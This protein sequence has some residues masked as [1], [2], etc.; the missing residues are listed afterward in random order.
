MLHLGLYQTH[1]QA[2]TE[3]IE[4]IS[5]SDQKNK[6]FVYANTKGI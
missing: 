1:Q 5:V 3:F 6:H 2:S 4:T